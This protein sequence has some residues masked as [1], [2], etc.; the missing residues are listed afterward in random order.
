MAEIDPEMTVTLR[1][2]GGW[3]WK[4]PALDKKKA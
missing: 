2:S 1:G 4:L 3:C